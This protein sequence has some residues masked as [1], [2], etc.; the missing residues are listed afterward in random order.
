MVSSRTTEEIAPSERERQRTRSEEKQLKK[1][2][3]DRAA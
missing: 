1:G 2:R 3:E